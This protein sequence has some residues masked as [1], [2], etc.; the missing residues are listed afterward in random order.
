[1][2]G[3]RLRVALRRGALVTAANWPL[4]AV[5]FT[6]DALY[7]AALGVPIVG[8]ALASTLL[9]WI[10]FPGDPLRASRVYY[11]TDT[12]VGAILLG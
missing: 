7:K 3:L 10:L 1:M 9:M 8:G 6:A 12:R 4:V 5:D 11:G 2:A